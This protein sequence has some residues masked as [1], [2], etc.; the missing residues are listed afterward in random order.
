MQFWISP[1]NI[2]VITDRNEIFIECQG[3]P[4]NTSKIAVILYIVMKITR[5][6]SLLLI[7]TPLLHVI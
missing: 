1:I 4:D 3:Q 7:P 2:I 5:A 6:I